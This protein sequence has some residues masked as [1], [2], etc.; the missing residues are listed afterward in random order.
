MF[1][2]TPYQ[3]NNRQAVLDMLF[4]NTRV[5]SHLDWTN[6]E[7]WLGSGRAVT[8]LAW[9]AVGELVGMMSASKPLNTISWLRLIA[10]DDYI[11]ATSLLTA[12]W[13][14]LS[15]A[16][17]THACRELL[18]LGIDDWVLSYL[19]TLGFSY[20]ER[21]ITMAR[22][23][24]CLP[25]I[26][27]S[28]VKIRSMDNGEITAVAAID[29][30]A[31]PVSWQMSLADL[32]YTARIAASR[33]I[34]SIDDEIV[35]YQ[36]STADSDRRRVHLARLAVYPQMQGRGIGSALLHNM[37]ETSIKRGVRSFTVNTQ[38]DNYHSQHIYSRYQ[39]FRNG[40][41]LSIWGVD[42]S[43]DSASSVEGK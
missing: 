27:T 5:H 9:D 42:C 41:D 43:A 16:M 11:P 22:M 24:G 26:D 33:T 37:L 8:L 6:Q 32:R 19:S 25:E 29:R 10:I 14:A 28:S 2:I 34:A 7:Q 39:F 36:V 3:R 38:A 12:L 15:E 23:D 40:Y 17:K 18:I 4:Y 13:K 1:K 35:G 31:F 30:A 21:I 20:R